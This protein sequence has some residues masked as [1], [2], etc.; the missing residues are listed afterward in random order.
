MHIREKNIRDKSADLVRERLIPLGLTRDQEI[1]IAYN[2][3]CDLE[4]AGWSLNHDE[5]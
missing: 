1:T 4:L 2:I 3:V 5:A